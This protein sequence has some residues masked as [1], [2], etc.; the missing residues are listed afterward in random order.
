[1]A[2]VWVSVFAASIGRIRPTDRT[3]RT[4]GAVPGR[5]ESRGRG[6][7]GKGVIGSKAA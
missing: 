1:M 4:A 5:V 3:G 2:V 7:A 6:G